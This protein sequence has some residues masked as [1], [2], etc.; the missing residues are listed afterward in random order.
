MSWIW[1]GQGP[2][3]F[4]LLGLGISLIILGI[5]IHGYRRHQNRSTTYYIT[6]TPIATSYQQLPP[7]VPYTAYPAQNQFFPPP[8]NPGN[9]QPSAPG[10]Y[11]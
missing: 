1:F 7:A 5:A 4:V 3:F 9:F 11:H 10:Y 6:S 2:A 8:V